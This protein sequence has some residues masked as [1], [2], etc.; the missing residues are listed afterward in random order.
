MARIRRVRLNNSPM[1]QQLEEMS[2]AA[3]N[4]ALEAGLDMRTIELIRLRASQLNGCGSCLK[5]HTAL[6]IEH[7]EIP[8]RIG[9]LTAWRDSDYFTATEEAVLELAEIITLVGEVGYDDE[10]YEHLAARL[11]PEQISAASWIAIVI[12][13][14]NRLWI[15]NNPPVR[16]PKELRRVED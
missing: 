3:T 6:A 8:Q 12:N 5:A 13:A 9:M 11:T 4:A 2:S 1:A 16:L 15:A 10:E 7:G 14:S